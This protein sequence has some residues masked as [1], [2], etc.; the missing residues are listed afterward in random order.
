MRLLVGLALSGLGFIG[1]RV[2]SA[3]KLAKAKAAEE[4]AR[5]KYEQFWVTKEHDH[6][7]YHFAQHDLEGE[8]SLAHFA[9]S[10]QQQIPVGFEMEGLTRLEDGQLFIVWKRTVASA[11]SG[12]ADEEPAA[13]Q[14]RDLR[15]P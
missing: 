11:E 14:E 10:L 7:V 3:A 8:P 6:L 9:D 2:S 12:G 4:E 1:G 15:V 5:S 13:D